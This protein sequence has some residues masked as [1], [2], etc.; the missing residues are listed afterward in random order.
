MEV[1]PH[2]GGL[3]NNCPTFYLYSSS[4]P[5][6]LVTHLP[7]L[8]TQSQARSR[9]YKM[10]LRGRERS[11]RLAQFCAWGLSPSQYAHLMC[12]LSLPSLSRTRV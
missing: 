12:S 5:R 6:A 7:H 1:Q 4:I 8:C 9:A 2:H 11:R 3:A 10:A